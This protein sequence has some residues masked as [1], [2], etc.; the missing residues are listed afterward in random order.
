MLSLSLQ[1]LEL[2]GDGG[3]FKRGT[4]RSVDCCNCALAVNIETLAPLVFL[5]L[6][7]LRWAF[8]SATCSCHDLLCCHRS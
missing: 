8:S 1:L 4:V 5:L 2:P 3:A 6:G 7:V